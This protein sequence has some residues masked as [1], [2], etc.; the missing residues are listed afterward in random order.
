MISKYAPKRQ[1]SL[2][3][4][5]EIN[6]TLTLIDVTDDYYIT[7]S[8]T[9]YRKYPNGYFLRK[10]YLN[11]K[12]G[13]LYITIVESDGKKRTHRLHRLVAKAYIPNPQHYPI[14]GHKDNDKTNCNVEN[15]Y[16]TTNAENIKKA[17]IDGLLI[18]D[19]GYDDSQS[20]PV[21]AYNEKFEEIGKYGSATECS[22]ILHVSKSTV[23]RHC[24]NETKTSIYSFIC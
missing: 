8:G 13:Y 1:N 21:I 9:V 23:F 15:L 10:A 20:I 11:T 22:K 7:P 2:I 6:E 18:N 17:V 19:K 12:N 14:V 16:W 4:I 3:D 5:S 24:N